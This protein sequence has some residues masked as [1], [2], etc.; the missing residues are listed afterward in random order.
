MHVVTRLQ[1][2]EA[3]VQA[4]AEQVGGGFD[5]GS[6][7]TELAWADAPDGQRVPVTLAYRPSLQRHDGSNPAL[8]LVCVHAHHFTVTLIF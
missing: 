4:Q 3:C 5:A 6:Y 2:T 8:L 1:L 7:H